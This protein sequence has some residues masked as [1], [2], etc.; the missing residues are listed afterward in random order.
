MCTPYLEK[1]KPTFCP[2][3]WNVALYIWLQLCQIL[4]DFNNFCSDKTEKTGH[5]FTYLLQRESVANDVINVSLFACCEPRHRRVEASYVRLSQRW[6]R[7]FWTLLMIAT[8]K[9]TMSTWQHWKFDYWRWLILFTF[10]VNVNE[11]RIIAFLTEKCCYLSLRSKVRT[12]LRWC[13]KFYYSRMYNF[14]TIKTI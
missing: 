13:G 3:S 10:A 4:T 11:Q 6:R 8:L 7:T 9:I 14:F 5:V 2:D 12:Q 1:L